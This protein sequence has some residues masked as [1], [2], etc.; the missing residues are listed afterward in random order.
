MSPRILTFL[1]LAAVSAKAATIYDG[2]LGT[3]PSAQ[4]LTYQSLFG[5][6]VET[7]GASSVTLDTTSSSSISAGYHG[8]AGSPSSIPVLDRTTGFTVSFTVRMLSESHAN[9]DRAGFSVIALASDKQ[10]IELD[11]WTNEIWEQTASPAFTHGAGMAFDTTAG[12]LQYDL[13]ITGG[14]YTLKNGATTL[15]TGS[16]KDYS[17]LNPVYDQASFLFFGD[18]TTSAQSQFE[19][20]HIAVAVPEPATAGLVAAGLLACWTGTRRRPPVSRGT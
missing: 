17:A 3:G 15:L 19:M 1:S 5:T 7:V 9:T 8:T 14:T 12:L 13:N 18:N 16:V 20:S 2:S 6:A 11:F 10:G 4:G